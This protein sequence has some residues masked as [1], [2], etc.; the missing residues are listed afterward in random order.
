MEI[1]KYTYDNNIKVVWDIPAYNKKTSTFEK[2]KLQIGKF[3]SIGEYVTVYLGGNHKSDWISTYPFHVQ[4]IHNNTFNK[5]KNENNE[6]PQTNGDVIIGN[7]VWI[8]EHVTIMSGI[9]IGD[10][11]IIATNSHVVKDVEP[12]SIIGGNPAKFIKYRFDKN[13]ID[14]LLE[15]KW[16][17]LDDDIINNLTPILCSNNPEKLF[18]FFQD[19]KYSFRKMIY[20][21]LDFFLSIRNECSN[22]LHDNRIF[23]IEET[24]EWF[25]TNKPI[26]YIVKYNNIDIGYFR[27]SNY[28]EKTIYIGCDIHKDF[29]GKK[30]AH[31]AYI[32]FINYILDKYDIE[33]FYLEVLENNIIAY[34]LYKKI[35]FIEENTKYQEISRNNQIINSI[36]MSIT[37]SEFLKKYNKL[38]KEL[39]NLINNKVDVKYN[40]NDEHIFIIGAYYL[41]R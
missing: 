6:Y 3:C 37:K 25:N 18:D 29:R 27:T 4:N 38:D 15:L 35:G 10:G 11:A 19:G 32:N 33:K 5:F 34:N 17:D 30:L 39:I 22:S 13:I 24:R 12:Y 7:D 26:F 40:F 14:K 36:L 2:P 1:G 16:W 20:E 21:D 41:Q 28:L 8:G 9:K 23:S 31:N